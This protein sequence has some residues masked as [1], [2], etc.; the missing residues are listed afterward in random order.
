MVLRRKEFE[1]RL[2]V[3]LEGTR[4]S[5]ATAEDVLIAKLEWGKKSESRRQVDDDAGILRIR[6]HE[7]DRDYIENWVRELG[8]EEQWN[9]ARGSG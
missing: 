4:L 7:L 5:M 6:A 1:R 8:L 3:D 9:A 2:S